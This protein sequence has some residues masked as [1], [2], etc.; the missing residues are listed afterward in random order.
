MTARSP[1]FMCGLALGR[2]NQ[3]EIIFPIITDA[4]EEV[5]D[6]TEDEIDS[7]VVLF[8]SSLRG[9]PPHAPTTHPVFNGTRMRNCSILDGR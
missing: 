8:G 5:Y 9:L 4:F 3:M 1:P 2:I 6:L 7:A